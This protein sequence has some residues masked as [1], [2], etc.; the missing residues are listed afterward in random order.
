MREG[1]C[2]T[3]VPQCNPQLA[4]V[5]PPKGGWATP[6]AF[7]KK[8]AQ[9]IS[10]SLTLAVSPTLCFLP[11]Q[12]LFT[13][14][15]YGTFGRTKGEPKRKEIKIRFPRFSS[16]QAPTPPPKKKTSYVHTH[17]L[18]ARG[19]GQVYTLKGTGLSSHSTDVSQVTTVGSLSHLISV[20]RILIFFPF[21]LAAIAHF[22]PSL[23]TR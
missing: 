14:A 15:F 3:P 20:S 22:T 16:F 10:A 17:T 6:L 9:Q 2:G 12:G 5:F 8:I 1:S 13:T 19:K 11:K 21:P 4:L 18:C 7:L 23:S